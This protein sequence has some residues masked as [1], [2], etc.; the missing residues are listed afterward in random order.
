M[1][2]HKFLQIFMSV[3]VIEVEVSFSTT[4]RMQHECSCFIELLNKLGKRDKMRGLMS[5]SSLF[6]SEFDKSN[7]LNTGPRMLDSIYHRASK[8]LK[9]AFWH[10]K[11]NILFCMTIMARKRPAQR[12][13]YQSS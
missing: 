6:R 3:K 9:I 10:E 4:L 1:S 2:K 13:D 12:L 7:K 8:I 11:G 5:I